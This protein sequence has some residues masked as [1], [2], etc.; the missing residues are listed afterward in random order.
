MIDITLLQQLNAQYER[1]E[2]LVL[3]FGFHGYS[4]HR[5]QKARPTQVEHFILEDRVSY[6]EY[7]QQ[8]FDKP[9]PER[10]IAEVC[11]DLRLKYR[12]VR[13]K[14]IGG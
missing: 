1:R 6:A 10:R 12:L 2:H 4:Y 3:V 13:E 11:T 8:L 5:E 9:L 7:L 14:K